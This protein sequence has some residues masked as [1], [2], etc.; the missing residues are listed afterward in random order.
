MPKRGKASKMLPGEERAPG[1][2]LA[3]FLTAPRPAQ[4]SNSVTTAKPSV[5]FPALG[6]PAP[7]S[8]TL[9]PSC[10]SAPA[11]VTPV[12]PGSTPPSHAAGT[13]RPA[14]STANPAPA[15]PTSGPAYTIG[16]TK[17]GSLPIRVENRNKGK[18]VTVVFNVTGDLRLLLS[19]L[20][21]AAGSGGVVRDDTVEIQGDKADFVEKFL[22]NKLLKKVK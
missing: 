10:W 1:V 17:K 19:E 16:R 14:S 7:S 5:E 11:I 3:D 8:T 22:K 20:K 6:S 13:G 12:V 15:P 4:P 2:S 9:A 18:K 21:Q